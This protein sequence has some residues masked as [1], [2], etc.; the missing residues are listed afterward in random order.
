MNSY[1]AAPHPS[2]GTLAAMDKE[3]TALEHD[4]FYRQDKVAQ[5]KAEWLRRL[6]E[7]HDKEKA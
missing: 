2:R 5:L 1:K 3:A 6:I 7:A 4:A